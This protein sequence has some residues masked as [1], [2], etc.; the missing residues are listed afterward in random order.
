MA[1]AAELFEVLRESNPD[2]IQMSLSPPDRE[3][4]E[5]L[6]QRVSDL[7]DR[8]DA[9]E[10]V[11][12]DMRVIYAELDALGPSTL[13]SSS[14]D[15]LLQ[16][17]ANTL[18][19]RHS[20]ADMV[21]FCSQ[22][23]NSVVE[24][25]QM[26]WLQS[27]YRKHVDLLN[28]I[29]SRGRPVG[30]LA[31]ML[32]SSPLNVIAYTDLRLSDQDLTYHVEKKLKNGRRALLKAYLAILAT[33]CSSE[34]DSFTIKMFRNRA[35]NRQHLWEHGPPMDDDVESLNARSSS[36]DGS[37]GNDSSDGNEP[38]AATV[39]GAVSPYSLWIAGFGLA[40]MTAIMC[41]LPRP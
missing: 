6:R 26:D 16:D 3:Q 29:V 25:D 10:D 34:E 4:L 37:D 12:E 41:T 2:T 28:S 9:G 5:S 36:D 1:S 23:P 7:L 32:D 15:P 30:T 35:N 11:G 8:E 27:T 21:G 18:D 31:D 38:E 24:V 19:L 33:Q 39:G 40:A 20:M 13:V 14:T 22:Y 17:M